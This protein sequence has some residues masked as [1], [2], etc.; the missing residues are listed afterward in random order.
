MSFIC[1]LQ[2]A[3][4]NGDANLISDLLKYG[5]NFK[6]NDCIDLEWYQEFASE[7]N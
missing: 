2:S 6:L 3:R 4:K 1:Q 7:I 5:E